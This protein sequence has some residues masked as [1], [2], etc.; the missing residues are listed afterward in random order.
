[1]NNKEWETLGRVGY[2]NSTAN[3]YSLDIP[4]YVYYCTKPGVN[5][6]KPDHLQA[7]W[8]NVEIVYRYMSKPNFIYRAPCINKGKEVE[9][10]KEVKKVSDWGF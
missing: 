9:P 2:G 1:M 7:D 6:E 10:V 8:K 4:G 5:H 3:E